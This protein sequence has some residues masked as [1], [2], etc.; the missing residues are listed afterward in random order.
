MSVM[1]YK[2]GGIHKMHGDNFD[3]VIVNEDEV[4]DSIKD[5]WYLT[6]TEALENKKTK[7]G[8]QESKKAKE[9]TLGVFNGMDEETDS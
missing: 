4:D 1:L 8:K 5:G 2:H 7:R 9:D 3:Y 6:T